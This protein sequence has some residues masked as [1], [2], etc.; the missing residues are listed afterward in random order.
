MNTTMAYSCY[1]KTY[2]TTSHELIWVRTGA[3]NYIFGAFWEVW[4][5]YGLFWPLVVSM[6]P[7]PYNEQLKL[8][9]GQRKNLK[10]YEDLQKMTK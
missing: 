10:I 9:Q 8:F 7:P 3:K 2:D 4:G 5:D 1:C 6:A